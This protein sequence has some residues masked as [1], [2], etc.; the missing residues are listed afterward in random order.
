MSRELPARPNLEHLKKQA[1][2]LLRNF[3]EGDAAARELFRAHGSLLSG[4]GSKLAD[5]QHV[6]AREYGFD[7]WAKLKEH[8]EL[9]SAAP[10][11]ALCAAVKANDAAAVAKLLE[12]HPQL[13]SGLNGPLAGYGFGL[14]ALYAAVQRSNREMIDVLLK[15]G[16]DINQRSDWWAGGFAPMDEAWRAPWLPAFLMERGA[17]LDVHS[18]TRLGM[19]EELKVMIT[20]NPALVHAR[21]G[22]GQT[23]LHFAH[24]VEIAEYLLAQGADIDARDIDHESTPVQ[25][26]VR[27]RQ[28]VARYLVQRGCRTDILMA[29]ALGDIELVRKHLDADPA[30]VRMSVS[31][32]YFPKLNPRAGGT[33]Y[34]WTLGRNKTAHVVGRE[35]RHENAFQLLMERSPEELKLA[36][37]CELGEEAVFQE[38]LKRNPN[39]VKSLSEDERRKL[40]EAAEANNTGAVRLMLAAGWPVD[41]RGSF[42]ATPLH[43]AG[44]NG[45]AEMAREI[46]RYHPPLEATD[47]EY[48]G[49][50]LGW[51]T[52][53]ST[54]SWHCKTGDYAA[55][56]EAMLQAG[57]K[58]H[59]RMSEEASEAVLEV[60]ERY[61]H[62]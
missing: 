41:V 28:D 21:G 19:F 27:D 38:M 53:G 4:A 47:A 6:L 36:L 30:C 34:I 16:A 13:K 22:D 20:A 44:F 40:A 42:G 58:V 57:A 11:E 51:A 52:F 8:V 31:D 35:F 62:K 1:K 18:A 43:W 54:N 46:L 61:E 5:A 55:T 7:T 23:P 48:N 17:R 49:T 9:A 59:A 32:K 15:A 12:Q 26:M 45:N 10:G 14:T 2:E 33:I 3:R 56:V 29:A 37:A 25:Y 60:L 50:P 39:L 24:S